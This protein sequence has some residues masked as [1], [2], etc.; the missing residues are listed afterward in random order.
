MQA[1][2]EMCP[3]PNIIPPPTQTTQ[4]TCPI[5][6]PPVGAFAFPYVPPSMGQVHES[7]QYGANPEASFINPMLVHD[8]E[9]RKKQKGLG[10]ELVVHVES[11]EAQ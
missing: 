10:K 5:P 6:S 2:Q 3:L 8:P 7:G 4:G 9:E 1:S 11:T